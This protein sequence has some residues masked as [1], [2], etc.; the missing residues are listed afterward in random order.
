[1]I[2]VRSIGGSLFNAVKAPHNPNVW[3]ADLD[4]PAGHRLF[5]VFGAVF[6]GDVDWFSQTRR[7][8]CNRAW[9]GCDDIF[10]INRNGT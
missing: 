8:D 5:S 4:P 9:R 2:L 7:R 10:L 3:A 6:L 1:M